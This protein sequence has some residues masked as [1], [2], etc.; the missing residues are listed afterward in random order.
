MRR[1]IKYS[2]N[3]VAAEHTFVSKRQ[4]QGWGGL[5]VTP[6]AMYRLVRST[7]SGSVRG[8]AE[9]GYSAASAM[10]TN[11]SEMEVHAALTC[12]G[13]DMPSARVYSSGCKS[14]LCVVLS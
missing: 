4:R 1:H 14:N 7:G 8:L 2:V 9:P 11:S 12:N 6:A 3:I 13:A 5:L 10:L